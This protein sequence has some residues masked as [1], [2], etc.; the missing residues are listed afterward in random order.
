MPLY[1]VFI[2]L[3]AVG[4]REQY[5]ISASAVMGLLLWS[6]RWRRP[7]HDLQLLLLATLVL[8]LAPIYLEWR[9]WYRYEPPEVLVGAG[10]VLRRWL[11]GRIGA[12]AHGR[13]ASFL[14]AVLVG[15]KGGLQ[16]DTIVAFGVLG[17]RHMLAVSGFHVGICCQLLLDELQPVCWQLVYINLQ[18]TTVFDQ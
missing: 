17:I 10:A 11:T 16:E 9:Q 18:A 1:P 4:L 3:M 13:L 15:D 12:V 14:Q 2:L 7:A 5:V 6:P 8:T